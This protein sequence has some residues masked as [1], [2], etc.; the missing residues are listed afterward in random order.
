MYRKSVNFKRFP[1]GAGHQHYINIGFTILQGH[2]R[3][4][5]KIQGSG[6]ATLNYKMYFSHNQCGIFNPRRNRGVISFTALPVCGIMVPKQTDRIRCSRS[7]V[8]E[9]EILVLSFDHF[10]TQY[11]LFGM[12]TR[13]RDCFYIFHQFSCSYLVN[14]ATKCHSEAWQ[15]R[16]RIF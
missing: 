16:V 7:A 6:M 12:T 8:E 4:G 9:Q 5:E 11:H 13:F 14:T 10:A 2:R 15:A 1:S 3:N